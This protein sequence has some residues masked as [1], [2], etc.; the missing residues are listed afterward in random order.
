MDT[1][2]LADDHPWL[3]GSGEK[4]AEELNAD[5]QALAEAEQTLVAEPLNAEATVLAAEEQHLVRETEAAF[6]AEEKAVSAEEHLVAE[7]VE[8]ELAKAESIVKK[9]LEPLEQEVSTVVKQVEVEAQ[10]VEAEVS[11]VV[12]GGAAEI[13]VVETAAEEEVIMVV[14][15]MEEMLFSWTFFGVFLFSLYRVSRKERKW[16]RDN[17]NAQGSGSSPY[18]AGMGKGYGTDDAESGPLA[19][20]FP[21]EKLLTP[22]EHDDRRGSGSVF[23]AGD[24]DA[25]DDLNE[26]DRAALEL[27]RLMLQERDASER[28]REA[29]AQAKIAKQAFDVTW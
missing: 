17:D 27:G 20:R 16:W 9:D 5:A 25:A 6:A 12:K 2:T 18:R 1:S 13:Q 29:A 28:M 24:E 26:E 22:R 11:G 14:G 19:R 3:V 7:K 15:T 23:D 21:R 8:L 4:V 10:V